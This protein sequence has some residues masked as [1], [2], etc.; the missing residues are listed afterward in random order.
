MS[1]KL[2]GHKED[3]VQVFTPVLAQQKEKPITSHNKRSTSKN[4]LMCKN[5]GNP[6]YQA[7]LVN[8]IFDRSNYSQGRTSSSQVLKKH[9]QKNKIL[10]DRISQ[11][12]NQSRAPQNFSFGLNGRD[13]SSDSHKKKNLSSVRLG[14][15]GIVGC[16]TNYSK[17]HTMASRKQSTL[18]RGDK[19][20]YPSRRAGT[21]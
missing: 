15:A 4:L 9:Y 2:N 17:H 19:H 6:Y 3:G 14:T 21:Q 11:T 13:K 16:S 20:G 12:R 1:L 18:S 8:N 5:G 10:S 7:P